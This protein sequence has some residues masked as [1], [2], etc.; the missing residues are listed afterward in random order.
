MSRVATIARRAVNVIKDEGAL[1]FAK[2]C[3]LSLEER[4]HRQLRK[5]RRI[6]S[7]KRR[8]Q[9]WPEGSPLVTIII[10][11]YNYGAFIRETIDSVLAQTFQRW[12]IR[13]VND[14]STDELTKQVL[15]ELN[16]PRTSVFHQA[17]QGLAQTRNNGAQMAL[18]KYICFLDADDQIEPTYL[19]KTLRLLESDESLG[20]CYSWVQCFGDSTA[21]WKTEDL[22]PFFLKKRNTASSHCVIRKES[23]EKVKATNGAGF[24]SKYNGYFEDWVFWIDMLQAGYRGVVIK[25]PLI[26]YRIHKNSLGATHKPNF[27]E[28]LRTLQEDRKEF[29]FDPSTARRLDGYLNERIFMENSL[30][31]L[32]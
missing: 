19:E 24:L 5:H 2:R 7:Q 9:P 8:Q 16:V 6:V 20:S 12:E 23:W 22:D 29:F 21:I 25:E 1:S 10:P 30:I 11:C 31:N 27:A 28:M 26:R 4:I 3:G 32:C 18:G 15:S 17:N 14:G 13:I